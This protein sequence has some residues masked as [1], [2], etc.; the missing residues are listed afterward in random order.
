MTVRCALRPSLK[1]TRR[2]RRAVGEASGRACRGA[3]GY[4]PCAT[5]NMDCRSTFSS[6]IDCTF[7]C[8]R[9]SCAHAMGVDRV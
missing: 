5:P 6:E 1:A 7:P 3:E 4:T 9:R 8:S 2:D